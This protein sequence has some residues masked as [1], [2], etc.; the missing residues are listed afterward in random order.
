[1]TTLTK[2]TILKADDRPYEVVHCPEWGGDVTIRTMMGSERDAYEQ[3]I[4]RMKEGRGPRINLLGLKARLVV[5]TALDEPGGAQLFTMNDVAELN[6]K[7][8]RVIDRLFQVASRLNG[9]TADDVEELLGNS[10]SSPTS[11][12]GSG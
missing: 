10:S 3:S 12:T 8:A 1:M 11:S 2:E 4:E 9:L 5:L 7:S 6:K